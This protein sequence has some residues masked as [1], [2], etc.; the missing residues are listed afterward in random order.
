MRGPGHDRQLG[1]IFEIGPQARRRVAV[2]QAI[3]VTGRERFLAHELIEIVRRNREALPARSGE[4]LA[5]VGRAHADQGIAAA[6]VEVNFFIASH[7]GQAVVDQR[8]NAESVGQ[9]GMGARHAT[10]ALED[11]A[12]F[13]AVHGF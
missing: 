4:Q 7:G 10:V 6:A 12:G 1:D 9:G 3:Q 2:S 11:A 5:K 13:N 8:G